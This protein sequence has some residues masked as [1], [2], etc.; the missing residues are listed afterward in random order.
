MTPLTGLDALFLHLETDEMP[1]HVGSVHLYE[2]PARSRRNFVERVRRHLAGRLHLCPTFTRRL[3][4]TPLDLAAPAWIDDPDVDLA[5]HVRRVDLPAPGSRAQLDAC[6]AALHAQPL[7]RSRPLWE[8]HLIHGLPKG[9]IAFYAKVHHA[10]V[11]GQAGVALARA[12]LDTTSRPRRIPPPP[13]TRPEPPPDRAGRLRAALANQLAQSGRLLGRLPALARGGTRLAGSL[14]AD[15]LSQLATGGAGAG[16]RLALLAPR[17]PLNTT[18]D[19]SRAYACVTVPLADARRI[20]AALGGTMNEVLLAL[21]SGALRAWLQEHDALPARP[22]VAAVPMS[23]RAEGDAAQNTQATMVRVGLATTLTDPLERY[24]AIRESS[25]AMKRSMQALRSDLP[26]DFPSLG[27]PWLLPG[28]AGLAGRARLADRVRIPAN[29]VISNVPGPRVP[30]YLAGARMLSYEP[31][32]IVTH[33]LGL[34]ITAMSYLDTLHVGLVACP[35]AVP[36]LPRLA[37]LLEAAH[38][39]LLALAGQES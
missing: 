18:I 1:M 3:V 7:D 5:Y 15:R 8:F 26:T 28:A 23:L 27:L 30:L 29:L 39:E 13:K 35:R 25:D 6:V 2:V 4:P 20:T 36:E 33:G 24:L 31:V 17:T 11:D 37:A 16:S 19:R 14:L 38:R 21:C 34:N 12:M 22:L 10:A 32:S 9:R